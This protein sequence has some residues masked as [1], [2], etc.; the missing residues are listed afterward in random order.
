MK[1]NEC[2]CVK[3][4]SVSE[5]TLSLNAMSVS[6]YTSGNVSEFQQPIYLI[7]LSPYWGVQIILEI[8]GHPPLDDWTPM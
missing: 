5:F 7:Q 2:T 4:G 1:S 8:R 3:T 6:S